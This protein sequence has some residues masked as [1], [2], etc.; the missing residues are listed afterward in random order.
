MLHWETFQASELSSMK[1]Q[2]DT[3][4][5]VK[6]FQSFSVVTLGT[7]HSADSSP[8]VGAGVLCSTREVTF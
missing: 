2:R 5:T 1:G 4:N 8:A 3:E 7:S 6:H